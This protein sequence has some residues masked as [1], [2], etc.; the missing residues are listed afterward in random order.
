SPELN[1]VSIDGSPAPVISASANQLV[2]TVPDFGT[3]CAPTRAVDV[4]VEVMFTGGPKIA[5]ARQPLAVSPQIALQP[6]ETLRL[7][8]ADAAC[9]EIPAGDGEYLIGIVNGAIAGTSAFRLVG[10]GG[11]ALAS[12]ASLAAVQTASPF[13]LPRVDA[14]LARTSAASTELAPP[15]D[16][17]AALH[18]SLLE[19]NRAHA[20]DMRA[21]IAATR[22][23]LTAATG[24]Q[25]SVNVALPVVGDEM[26]IR[27]PQLSDVCKFTTVRARVV[28]V[29]SRSIVLEDTGSPTART[30]DAQLNEMGREF[31]EVMFPL[32]LENFG[33]PLALDGL[34][35]NNGRILM[36]FTPLVNSMGQEQINGFVTSIDF[37][38]PEA[39]GCPTSNNAEIFYAKAALSTSGADAWQRDIR[40]TMI[41]EVKHLTS[42]AE[43]LSRGGQME[44]SWLEE[45]TAMVSEEI[46]GRTIYG[47]HQLGNTTYAQ[48]LKC[49]IEG[50]PGKPR[51]LTDHFAFLAQYMDDTEN[52]SPIYTTGPNDFSY[53]GSGWALVRWAIDQYATTE[54]GFLRAL[55]QDATRTGVGN[56]LARTNASWPTLLADFTMALASDDAPGYTVTR[57][58][59]TFP[60]W[61]LR[62][63]FANLHVMLGSIRSY[64]A[65]PYPLR[66]HTPAWGDFTLPVGGLRAGSA[67]HVR[68]VGSTTSS[69]LLELQSISGGPAPST[70]GMVVVRTK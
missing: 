70:L 2:V 21:A 41:H 43:R 29:G 8:G 31:D 65:Q 3:S 10:V 19:Q 37:G 22:A 16:A 7:D 12:T 9:Q 52:R 28:R 17:G 58:A 46:F 57:R 6:G 27:V 35:D 20:R 54:S 48:S 55:T 34:T 13:R 61:N 36:L 23:A 68:L 5:T 69:Q 1:R 15:S 14:L 53:Y 47:Y 38:T 59:A 49:E 56:L 64:F 44:E 4:R 62:D 33:N 67:T 40:S 66:M 63:I 32:L 30:V 50:C 42:Y 45:S 24:P 39:T 11:D 25:L 60:S 26:T 18:R 51:V